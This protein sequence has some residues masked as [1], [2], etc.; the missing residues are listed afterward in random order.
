MPSS[1]ILNYLLSHY[2]DILYMFIGVRI[3]TREG[4]FLQVVVH[5]QAPDIQVIR[6]AVVGVQVGGT[7][8]AQ[9]WVVVSENYS[10]FINNTQCC[11][12]FKNFVEN[13]LFKVIFVKIKKIF[14]FYPICLVLGHFWTFLR[15]I[16]SYFLKICKNINQVQQ[17][18]YDIQTWEP[19]VVM[20]AEFRV[21]GIQSL[22]SGS[23]HGLGR[24]ESWQQSETFGIND[25]K[26]P[27][28]VVIHIITVFWWEIKFT[29]PFV[30]VKI[31]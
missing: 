10:C 24:G 28:K 30:Y 12:Q 14:P 8:E 17:R 18:N 21:E 27:I 4:V 16:M 22:S 31:G 15:F 19:W 13:D 7:T 23:V 5:G 2:S 1:E 26:N 3:L 9:L 29:L 6:L 20:V 25:Q 11:N